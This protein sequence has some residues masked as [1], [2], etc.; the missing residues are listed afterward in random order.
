MNET[1]AVYAENVAQRS[2]PPLLHLAKTQRQAPRG[3]QLRAFF[4]FLKE[5]F[6]IRKTIN[7]LH[8]IHNMKEGQAPCDRLHSCGK[9][10]RP[11]PARSR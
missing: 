9:S 7:A 4:F 11:N 5:E 10:I 2:Q 3:G 8:R 1:E 6:H